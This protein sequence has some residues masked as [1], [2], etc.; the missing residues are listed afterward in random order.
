MQEILYKDKENIQKNR[1]RKNDLEMFKA[2]MK[3]VNI[4]Q[5]KTN[6]NIDKTNKNI[7]ET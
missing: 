2:L 5:N 3:N 7:D 4:N 6:K 1:N